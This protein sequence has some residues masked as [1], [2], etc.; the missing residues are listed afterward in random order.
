MVA[1]SCGTSQRSVRQRR[2]VRARLLCS[3]YRALH[4][5]P[6][7]VHRLERAEPEERKERYRKSAALAQADKRVAAMTG[8]RPQG[9]ADNGDVLDGRQ[10]IACALVS[11]PPRPF[12]VCTP[13]PPA[14]CVSG[15]RRQH[16][17]SFRRARASFRARISRGQRPQRSSASGGCT[18]GLQAAWKGRCCVACSRRCG[19]TW[20]WGGSQPPQALLG[21]LS[22]S[23]IRCPEAGVGWGSRR[24]H[25]RCVIRML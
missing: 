24:R 10:R 23:P 18:G 4:N 19:C 9:G 17:S 21:R 7:R 6:I 8:G 3:R 5:N 15:S 12:C 22:A 11:P 25:C 13:P 14:S 16:S 20:L 1:A 2:R